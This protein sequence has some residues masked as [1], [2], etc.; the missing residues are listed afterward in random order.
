LTHKKISIKLVFGAVQTLMAFLAIVLALFLKFNIFNV[1][2]SMSIPKDGLNFYIVILLAGGFV[3][4][5]SGIFQVY[6]WW[7]SI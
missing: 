3:F 2:S 5:V 1:Q 7:E 6:D 4:V